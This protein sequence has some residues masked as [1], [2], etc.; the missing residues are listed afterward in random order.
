[1]LSILAFS[2]GEN[3]PFYEYQCQN[4]NY[5]TEVMQSIN[6]DP[7]TKCPECGA[8]ALR[9]K[10]FPAGMIFKGDGFYS[11]EYRG[12]DYKAAAK[13]EKEAAGKSLAESNKSD[14]SSPSNNKGNDSGSG[15][16]SESSSDSGT[17]SMSSSTGE[18]K[19]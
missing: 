18:S 19:S 15:S 12:S 3:M 5:E 1:M 11:T 9:R 4:C 16:N 7:L 8:E 14:Q 13:S 2:I 10:I 6:A 17:G